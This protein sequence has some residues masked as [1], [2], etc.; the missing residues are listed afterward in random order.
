[1]SDLSQ[2]VD[3]AYSS[4]PD[5][6]FST[7]G[8]IKL[9]KSLNLNKASGPD[10]ISARVLT[11]CAEEIVP[12]LTVLFTQSFNSGELPNDWLTAN[13]TP[14]HK[15]GDKSNPS[16][17]RPISLTSLCYKLMEHILCHNIMNYLESNHI[18][19]D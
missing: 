11:I 14:I 18:L 1:M 6:P 3:P 13:I 15:K 2:S 16:N 17:Y 7:D 9:I 8:I 12:I 19:N 4:I 5:T 10:N